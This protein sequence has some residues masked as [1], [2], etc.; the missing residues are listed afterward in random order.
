[1]RLR[2]LPEWPQDAA[3]L[4]ARIGIGLAWVSHGW[5]KIQDPNG[6]AVEFAKMGV[7]FPTVSAWYA[8]IVEFIVAITL[9]I[10]LGS[11]IAAILLFLNAVGIIYF[12]VGIGGLAHWEGDSQLVVVLGLGSLVAGF[13]GGRFTIDRLIL[14]RATS[15]V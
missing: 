7:Y 5:S 9:I 6:V 14:S 13:Y 15:R 12:T 3:A 1:M 11:P 10:G 4:I 2:E 8:S